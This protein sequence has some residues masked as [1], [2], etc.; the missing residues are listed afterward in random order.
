MSAARALLVSCGE[1]AISGALDAYQAARL[2]GWSVERVLVPGG[3]WWLAEVAS[4]GRLKKLI[5]SRGSAFEAVSEMLSGGNVSLITL[6]GHQDCQW[7][8][9]RFPGDSPG[10]LVR[11][12]GKDL[13]AARDEIRRIA[14]RPLEISGDMLIRGANGLLEPRRLFP[15]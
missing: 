3:C 15:S 13:Y 6:V 5:A 8:R 1:P 11:R 4:A 12:I 14:G 9:E 2:P 10:D 7:Y